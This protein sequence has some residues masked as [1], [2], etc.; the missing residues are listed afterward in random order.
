MP[1]SFHRKGHVHIKTL[2]QDGMRYI[3]AIM[4]CYWTI[5]S[6]NIWSACWRCTYIGMI[7]VLE[8]ILRLVNLQLQRQRCSR[9]E[10]FFKVEETMFVF[11]TSKRTNLTWLNRT[12]F[13]VTWNQSY[14]FLIYSYNAGVVVD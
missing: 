13:N 5:L 2:T 7:M 11:K 12:L 8:P 6:Q 9:V 1:L 4:G 3:F 10:R 14:D